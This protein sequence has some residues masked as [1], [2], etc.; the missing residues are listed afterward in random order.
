MIYIKNKVLIKLYV[1]M[2]EKSYDVFVPI[3]K[4]VEQIILLLGEA[5]NELTD[6]T[7]IIQPST[8]LCDK[9]TGEYFDNNKYVKESGIKNGSEV[10]LI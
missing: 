8:Q 3:N 5:V 2:V 6:G 10:I 9:V 4:K 1:P 7:F